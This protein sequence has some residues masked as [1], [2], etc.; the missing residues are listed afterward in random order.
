MLGRA[1]RSIPYKKREVIGLGKKVDNK[2]RKPVSFNK[3][4]EKDIE[5]LSYL[6]RRNFSGYVK[7]L[8]Q[9][10][11]ARKLREKEGS[12]KGIELPLV[13]K[14]TEVKSVQDSESNTELSVAERYS[15]MRSEVN[16]PVTGSE[17]KVYMGNPREGKGYP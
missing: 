8:I 14:G 2:V 17:P 15:R 16:R 7:K 4:K 10:D 5:M 6:G 3:T 13:S 11:M 9:E 12:S 1:Y